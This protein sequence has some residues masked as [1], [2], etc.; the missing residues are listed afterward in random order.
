MFLGG[1]T[2][3]EHRSNGRE[4][5]EYGG[6]TPSFLRRSIVTGAGGSLAVYSPMISVG[7]AV[8]C[9]RTPQDWCP[10][11]APFRIQAFRP[12]GRFRGFLA[13]MTVCL[14]GPFVGKEEVAAAPQLNRRAEGLRR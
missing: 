1:R 9:Y 3:R 8:T 13:P 7:K 4:V 11:R 6:M 12:M 10:S 5:L 14:D 2:P